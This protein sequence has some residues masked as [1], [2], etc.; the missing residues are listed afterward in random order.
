MVFLFAAGPRMAAAADMISRYNAQ[1][2]AQAA[3]AATLVRLVFT[4]L[5]VGAG[6]NRSC[7]PVPECGRGIPRIPC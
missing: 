1:R 4:L 7:Q 3:V 2:H 6:L 5:G